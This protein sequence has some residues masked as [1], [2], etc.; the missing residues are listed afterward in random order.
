MLV[1]RKNFLNRLKEV[2]YLKFGNIKADWPAVIQECEQAVKENPAYWCSLVV[3]LP[4]SWDKLGDQYYEE[5]NKHREH[6]YRPDNTRSWETTSCQPQLQMA[7]EQPVM[8]KLPLYYPISR[9]TLQEPGNIMPWHED[10]FFYFRRKYPEFAE[11]IVRFIVFQKDW[12]VGQIIQAGNSIISHWQ[13]GDAIVWYP[14]RMH[15]SCNAGVSGKWTQNITG[16]LK[17]EF[18]FAES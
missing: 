3:D 13:A 10:K 8:D 7:W 11:Y 4:D 6:G 17:E 16:I 12:D 14:S 9:P 15:L 2:D 1:S 18:D 5:L